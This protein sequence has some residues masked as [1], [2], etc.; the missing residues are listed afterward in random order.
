MA[1]GDVRPTTLLVSAIGGEGGGVFAAWIVEAAKH[2]GYP[3][4]STSIPGVAQRTGATTYYLEVFPVLISDLED[5]RPVLAIYPGVGDVDIMIA[6]EFIEAGRAIG[7][8]FITPDR[9]TLIASTHRVYSIG[10][11]SGMGDGRF[12]TARLHEV[13]EMRAKQALL[14]NFRESAEEVGVSL[15]AV[16]L[17]VLAASGLLPIPRASFEEAIR[18]GNIA[19]EANLRGFAVGCDYQF[20][21][22]SARAPVEHKNIRPTD[23]GPEELERRVQN[24]F[25]VSAQKILCEGVRRLS[26]YQGSAYA[27]SYLD[28]L[29]VIR[30]VEKTAGGEGELTKEV[31]RQL[32]LRMSYE[33]VIRVAQLK[34][35]PSRYTRVRN[36]IRANPNEP[37]IIIDYFKPG[38]K[39][40]SAILPPGVARFLLSWS[41]RRGWQE[42]VHFGLKVRST[43]VFGYFLLRLLASLKRWRP[44][45]YG[46]E[47]AQRNI[48]AW[49]DDVKTACNLDSELAL[50][51]SGCAGLIKGYGDTIERGS[52]NFERIRESIVVPALSGSIDVKRATD[53]LVN[54]RA[55]ALSDPDGK[56]L[57]ELLSEFDRDKLTAD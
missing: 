7:N 3:V 26:D 32:A 34:S 36:E 29:A 50:E 37:I 10:E 25:P 22:Q 31:G 13:I 54:A 41:Q 5:N 12:D 6:S 30:G 8:G 45:S 16:L 2:A 15:N 33:D 52:V 40:F 44:Y 9:T 4:Q 28:R 20:S 35:A 21:H 55:A 39:E 18:K 56:R 51:I 48:E 19:V 49:L 43:T 11:R 57:T 27:E 38:I 23:S 24:D 14:G 47:A 46:Y 42:R 1:A 53:A 17:G